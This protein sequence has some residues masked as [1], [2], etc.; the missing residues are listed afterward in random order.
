MQ[1]HAKENKDHAGD[2]IASSLLEEV[3]L[4]GGKLMTWPREE[5]AER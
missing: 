2:F 4:G 3:E 1:V 5:S